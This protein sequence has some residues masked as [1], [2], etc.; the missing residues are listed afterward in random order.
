MRILL[1]SFFLS[2]FA[3][4]SLRAENPNLLW[5][6]G[7]ADCGG[8]GAKAII[9]DKF[10]N[11][12]IAGHF[13]HEADFDPGNGV[14]TLTPKA[15][16]D[17]YILKLDSFGS[18][19][20]AKTIGGTESSYAE[21]IASDALGNIY[22]T[23]FFNGTADFDPGTAS[24]IMTSTGSDNAYILK[25]DQNG[26]FMW[27]KQIEGGS[28]SVVR[29][30]TLDASNNI[31]VTGSFSGKT[32]FDPSKGVYTLTSSGDTRDLFIEKLD[33]SGNFVWAK[34][35]GGIAADYGCSISV[36]P[37]G[38]VYTVG[39]YFGTVDFDPGAEIYNLN[40]I[41]NQISRFI[42]K[43]STTGDFVWARQIQAASIDYGCAVAVDKSGN[44]Y[45]TGGFAGIVDVDPGE[46]IFTL[47]SSGGADIFILKLDKDGNFVWAKTIGSELFDFAQA[48]ALDD[49]SNVYT[50]GTFRATADF[51]PGE[52]E[53]LLTPSSSNDE[54]FISKLDSYGNFQWALGI[55]S[56]DS[57]IGNSISVDSKG[58]VYSTGAFLST[59][60]F[61]PGIKN[62]P[63]T[64][65]KAPGVYIQKLTQT[66]VNPNTTEDLSEQSTSI[67]PNPASGYVTFDF[68]R[69]ITNGR[70]KLMNFLGQ[71][72]AE[73]AE[74][75]GH[76]LSI[77]ISTQPKGLYYF[78]VCYAG[79]S[80]RVRV[81]KG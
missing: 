71:T 41:D 23:G 37:L 78:E 27:V 39:Q 24:F 61:D 20:W 81:V 19:V 31:Y 33:E 18:F 59:V 47:I 57:D 50:T 72:V 60:D 53:V 73:I 8:D 21:S 49:S 17:I 67:Y 80:E 3:I 76:S 62:N 70:I 14:F 5:A 38:N 9:S 46:G 43:L 79:N 34:Q 13:D 64:S 45:T 44:V 40:S 32:D 75:N 58:N 15:T 66:P 77:D 7:I 65:T 42:L 68:G 30:I 1:I 35:I 52:Q 16:H 2:L 69:Q 4:C 28:F 63:L 22:V 48:I 12:Y 56:I 6:K 10:Q 54:I 29:S 51:D 26:N 36:D 11:V 74:V 25:L 55:G